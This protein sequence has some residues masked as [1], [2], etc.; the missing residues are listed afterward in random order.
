MDHDINLESFL[1]VKGAE[2]ILFLDYIEK[3]EK[4]S[5]SDTV[6]HT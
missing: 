5:T 2:T 1:E 6:R 4:L 3:T